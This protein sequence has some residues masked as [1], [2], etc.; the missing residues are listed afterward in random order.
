LTDF[1][2]KLMRKMKAAVFVKPGRIALDEKLIPE[3][4]PRGAKD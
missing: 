3:I 1:K 4:G 2:S